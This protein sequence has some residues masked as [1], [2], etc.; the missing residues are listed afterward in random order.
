[1][2][3]S[4]GIAKLGRFRV[5][6]FMQRGTVG[7]VFR[8]IRTD[9]RSFEDLNL[10]SDTLQRLSSELRGLVLVTGTA[11]SGK[12][13]ALSSMV[14]YINENYERHVITIEDPIEFL[15]SDKKGAVTQREVG[16]DTLS[17]HDALKR[18]IRQSPDVI[19]I[20]E[21]RDA[22]TVRSAIMAA[23]MGNLVL[24]TLHTINA[25]SSMERIVNFFPPYQHSQVL[26]QLSGT[27]KGVVSLRLLPALDGKGL[28]PASEIMLSTPTVRKLISDGTLGDLNGVIASSE[29]EGMRTFNQDLVRLCNGN[30]ITKD[31]AMT[32][33]DNP[34]ELELSLSGLYSGRDT[35]KKK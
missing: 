18:V 9:I 15:H 32:Y 10:P 17:F 33:S 11:G 19:M 12:S 8:H 22:E 34:S 14:E 25:K 35:H 2:D 7:I 24:S 21:M 13:T 6:V 29:I 16:V 20:G 30:K 26:F 3:F 28:I 5:N 27:I 1:F 23:E 4:Y 31:V